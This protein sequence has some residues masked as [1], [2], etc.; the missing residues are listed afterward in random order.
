MTGWT[1]IFLAPPALFN[2]ATSV[3]LLLAQRRLNKLIDTVG[4]RAS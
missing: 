4:T 2:L 3:L 1:A